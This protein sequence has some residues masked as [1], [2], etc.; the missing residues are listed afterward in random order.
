MYL[1]NMKTVLVIE[2]EALIRQYLVET[3]VFNRFH[4]IEASDGLTGL[5]LIRKSSPDLI[6]C[7]IRM[8]FFDGYDVLNAVRQD[9]SLATIPF[10]FLTARAS[11]SEVRQGMNLGADDYLTKPC[12]SQDLLDAIES[13]LKKRATFSRCYLDQVEAAKDKLAQLV[14]WDELTDLPN[15]SRFQE[16]LKNLCCQLDFPSERYKSSIATFAIKITS[17]QNA[18]ILLGQEIGDGLLQAIATRLTNA[19]NPGFVARLGEDEFG[20]ILEEVG[21]HPSMSEFTQTLLSILNVPYTILG[22]E[23]RLH[24]HIGIALFPQHSLHPETLVLQAD[25]AMRWCQEQVAT[26]YRFYNPAIAALENERQLITTDLATALER[27]Q[28]DLYYQPQIDLLTGK[29]S[30]VEA[31]ARWTH[32]KRGVVSPESFI[33]VAENSGLIAPLGE[34]VLRSACQQSMA[35]SEHLRSPISISVNLSMRQFENPNLPDLIAQILQETRMDPKLL[36]LELTESCL[37]DQVTMTI[38]KLKQLKKLGVKL[39]IDDFGTGYSSLSYLSQLP[40][41]ELKIDQSFVRQINQDRNA[42][43]ISSTIISMARSL[44][45][46]VVAEGIETQQQMDFLINA[47]CHVGQGFLYSKPMDSRSIVSW[48]KNPA[49]SRV[50]C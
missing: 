11:H 27:S 9:S 4:V 34:W 8:P 3:L 43:M 48:F 35:W 15:R 42:T 46:K 24:C 37:M 39:A 10:I 17:Y 32:A 20:V 44:G 31:L 38:E 23:V 28:L 29:L 2:D 18:C 25:V 36:V 13:A 19:A 7:D 26:G 16:K 5:D 40:I 41:D 50:V 33:R 14:H 1:P 47:G 12:R 21:D 45:L 30:G 6:L 22:Q 49:S